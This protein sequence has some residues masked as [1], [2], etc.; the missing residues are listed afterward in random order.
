MYLSYTK[1]K[2]FKNSNFIS[3]RMLLYC[4]IIINLLIVKLVSQL[5]TGQKPWCSVHHLSG[6]TTF[7]LS[8]LSEVPSTFTREEFKNKLFSL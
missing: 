8:R 4:Q 5:I 7:C 6:D 3:L 2:L 1:L